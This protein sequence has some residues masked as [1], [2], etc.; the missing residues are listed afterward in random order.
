MYLN[1]QNVTGQITSPL[2][3]PSIGHQSYGCS[4]GTTCA[5]SNMSNIA[6]SLRWINILIYDNILIFQ[7][8]PLFGSN[9][10]AVT[11]VAKAKPTLLEILYGHYYQ[12]G[13]ISSTLSLKQRIKYLIFKALN[14]RNHD[15]WIRGY[16]ITNINDEV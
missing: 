1:W 15:N 11:L 4:T 7:I 6:T 9:S 10:A 16:L 13:L 5:T 14:Q 2:G 3:Y 8:G 12:T